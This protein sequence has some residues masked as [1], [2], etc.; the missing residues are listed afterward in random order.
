MTLEAI[1]KNKNLW[2]ALTILYVVYHFLTL[3]FS[4]IVWQDE[5]M[6][7][8]ISV[9]FLKH[10]TFYSVSDPLF[11]AGH[12]HIYYGPVFFV[13][14]SFVIGLLGNGPFQGRLLG[15]FFG[16]ILLVLVYRIFL[17]RASFKNNI[18]RLIFVALCLD[19]FIN[20]AMHRGRND[21][22][23]ITFFL[24]SFF[25]LHY[26]NIGERFSTKR[27][28]F[29]SLLYLCALMT[30]M[31]M[32]IFLGPFAVYFMFHFVT[33]KSNRINLVKAGLLWLAIL[34]SLYSCWVYPMFGGYIDYYNFMHSIKDY[35]PH[36]LFGNLY[37]P[38]EAYLVSFVT[39]VLIVL[40]LFVNRSAFKNPALWFYG[41]F[42]CVFHLFV[43]DVGPYS[44]LILPIIYC[45]LLELL[46][47]YQ[48][49]YSLFYK[50]AIILVLSFNVFIF[51]LKALVLFGS[52]DLKKHSDVVIFISKN[53]PKHARVVGDEVYYYAVNANEDQFQYMHL[54]LFNYDTIERYRREQYDYEYFVYS[55]R[56]K[57]N[58]RIDFLELYS[59]NAKLVKVATFKK[60]P[61]RIAQFL[62]SLKIYPLSETGYNGV[63]Y[64][65][66][67]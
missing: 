38:V 44:I 62:A 29:S 67:K 16:F 61:S 17:K 20:M 34:F 48:E 30:S 22:L 39:V 27:V 57:K 58:G 36:L 37:L 13:L 19:P 8:D 2:I 10:H 65:R 51:C 12:Q 42:M 21:T 63:I 31:R 46:P 59:R 35:F 53:I 66:V 50:L 15:L 26:S 49:K 33:E 18:S 3:S 14:N 55:D 52:Y 11:V 1:F 43:G 54:Q 4:P 25:V 47:Y 7:N 60:S 6:Y 9:D 45:F 64:K 41:S 32:A 28:L 24:S 40:T 5:T 23:G 56:I